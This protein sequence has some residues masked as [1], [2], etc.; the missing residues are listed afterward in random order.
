MFFIF[1]GLLHSFLRCDAIGIKT[2]FCNNCCN[3]QFSIKCH[4]HFGG[5]FRPP[6]PPLDTPLPKRTVCSLTTKKLSRLQEE[7]EWGK[8]SV[9]G[10]RDNYFKWLMRPRPFGGANLDGANRRKKK[11]Q[12]ELKEPVPNRHCNKLVLNNKKNL[13]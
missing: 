12:K 3:K 2:Y 4:K 9:R 13:F 7:W 8:L 6:Q 10:V 11:T 1:S 5:G